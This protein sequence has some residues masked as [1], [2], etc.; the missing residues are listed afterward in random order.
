MIEWAGE[1]CARMNR[2]SWECQL[3]KR[4]RHNNPTPPIWSHTTHSGNQ[5]KHFKNR[6]RRVL[7]INRQN[8]TLLPPAQ[9]RLQRLMRR[10]LSIIKLQ[11][12]QRR[13]CRLDT[14]IVSLTTRVGEGGTEGDVGYI[15]FTVLFNHKN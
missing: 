6:L 9:K 11:I 4:T 7:I 5:C 2:L 14:E 15:W 8:I 1:H 10:T 12:L 3:A 13:K